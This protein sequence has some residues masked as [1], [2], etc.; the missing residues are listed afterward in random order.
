MP[1]FWL[2]KI[3]CP[4]CT[5]APH[6]HLHCSP[7]L[8][9]SELRP[10]LWPLAEEAAELL[11]W[12]AAFF[13]L[14]VYIFLNRKVKVNGEEKQLLMEQLEGRRELFVSLRDLTFQ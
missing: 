9:P 3:R 1:L 14:F 11:I 6:Q 5:S 13:P 7:V 12:E 2:E 8:S 10:W 4:L